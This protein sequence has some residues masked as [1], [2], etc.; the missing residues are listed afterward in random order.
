MATSWELQQHRDRLQSNGTS[1]SEHSGQILRLE[2]NLE[3]FQHGVANLRTRLA[4]VESSH[5]QLESYI[6]TNRGHQEEHKATLTQVVEDIGL[7][8]V[9]NQSTSAEMLELRNDAN[10]KHEQLCRNQD[11]L[12]EQLSEILRHV[13]ASSR[14]HS[15][16][17]FDQMIRV[18]KWF[19]A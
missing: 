19:Y 1:I 14:K 13:Q 15:R 4:S 12:K 10:A 16:P 3:S 7:I 6:Q 8:K 11:D 17:T 9:Q 2:T 18:A 5:Q